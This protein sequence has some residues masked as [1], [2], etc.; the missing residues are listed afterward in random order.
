MSSKSNAKFYEYTQVTEPYSCDFRTRLLAGNTDFH[1][2]SCHEIYFLMDGKINY[3]VE[4]SCYPLEAGD[5]I[6]FSNQ[7]IHKAI[8]L[9]DEPFRRLVLH[10]NPQ[11]FRA[12]CTPETNLLACFGHKPGLGNQV[13]LLPEE[14]EQLVTMAHQAE[15]NKERRG[16]GN[17]IMTLTLLLQILVIVNRAYQRS[18]ETPSQPVPHRAQMIMDYIDKNLSMPLT[19]DSIA[20]DLLLDKYYLSHLFKQETQSSIFQ[21][22]LVKRIALAKELLADGCNVTEACIG[23]GFNDYS[24]FI[25][26]FRLTTGYTP[27][28][29]RKMQLNQ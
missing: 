24:N 11:Y 7:E 3:F 18:Q 9:T 21:Y 28:Q 10:I 2:H 19:L 1:M 15:K 29:F 23:A 26:S 27:G 8:N 22:I 12:F 6:V 25:R 13:R 16:Y 4:K 5:L 17:D 20:D 14:Q